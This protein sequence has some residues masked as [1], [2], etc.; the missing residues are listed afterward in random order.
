MNRRTFIKITGLSL[1]VS[2]TAIP[3]ATIHE[4]KDELFDI[5]LA[6]WSLNRTL[7]A[8]KMTNLDFPKVARDQYDIHCIEPVDQFFADKSKDQAYLK[9]FRKRADDLGVRIGL[10][11]L[12]TNGSLGTSSA[13]EMAK[14]IDK[15]KGWIDAA[16]TLGCKSVR[17]NARG[18]NNA[19]PRASRR[20]AS[21]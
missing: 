21:A 3:A 20:N 16:K 10:L 19:T 11:M 7:R 2:P 12:D 1:C 6:Q 5:S 9:D 17:I 4:P 14:S 18:N 13:D 8:G 15:T